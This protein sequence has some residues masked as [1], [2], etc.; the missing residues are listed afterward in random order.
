M[1]VQI[2]VQKDT[3]EMHFQPED[4]VK[5]SGLVYIPLYTPKPTK[6]RPFPDMQS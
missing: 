1:I 4:V 6:H 3:N 5:Q 2:A